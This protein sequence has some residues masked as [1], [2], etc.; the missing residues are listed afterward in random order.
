MTTNID[1]GSRHHMCFDCLLA[2]Y[3]EG[4]AE[5]MKNLPG[6]WRYIG[7]DWEI[8]SLQECETC[9]GEVDK[10]CQLIDRESSPTWECPG[11][12]VTGIMFNEMYTLERYL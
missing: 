5:S 6:R 8:E 9:E 12:G 1:M 4:S 10:D 11:C 2:D 7:H 3:G